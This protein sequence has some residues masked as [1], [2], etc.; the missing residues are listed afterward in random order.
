MCAHIHCSD[1]LERPVKKVGILCRL[2]LSRATPFPFVCSLHLV[3]SRVI[4]S[5][6]CVA[7]KDKCYCCGLILTTALVNIAAG[8][9]VAPVSINHLD[10]QRA[11]SLLRTG[12]FAT[13]DK[14][15]HDKR[16]PPSTPALGNLERRTRV[17][18][19]V[20]SASGANWPL[21]GERLIITA[22]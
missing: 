21:A 22:G 5:V 16:R 9:I 6:R 1:S 20:C 18:P 19:F 4:A 15:R 14:G 13:L 3:G 2:R 11:G 10:I 8:T 17:F 12:H 7:V